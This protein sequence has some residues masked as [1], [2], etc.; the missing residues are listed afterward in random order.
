MSLEQQLHSRRGLGPT[1][2]KSLDFTL[3]VQ[4]KKTTTSVMEGVL[5]SKVLPAPGSIRAQVSTS[6]CWC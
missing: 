2:D 3:H 1:L 4:E 6:S 5:G